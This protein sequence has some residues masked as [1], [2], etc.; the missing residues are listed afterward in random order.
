MQQK[1]S[2]NA[3]L[4]KKKKKKKLGA[5]GGWGGGGG[6]GG[7]RLGEQALISHRPG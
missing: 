3:K 4:M 5:R 1:G 7:E 2:I 6:G